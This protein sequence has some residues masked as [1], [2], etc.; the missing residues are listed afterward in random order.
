MIAKPRNVYSL[1]FNKVYSFI[2]SI[3]MFK[4]TNNLN[5]FMRF[6]VYLGWFLFFVLTMLNMMFFMIFHRF[7]LEGLEIR[8]YTIML[9]MIAMCFRVSL[10][11]VINCEPLFY[12]IKVLEP[13]YRSQLLDESPTSANLGNDHGFI[14]KEYYL[15]LHRSWW[16]LPSSDTS[17]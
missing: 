7:M 11:L 14:I 10:M 2:V 1:R 13:S 6:P 9:W 17:C 16:I 3:R 8:L 12:V 5:M 4:N 15:H